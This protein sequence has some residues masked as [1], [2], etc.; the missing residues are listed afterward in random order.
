M[1]KGLRSSGGFHIVGKTD[2]HGRSPPVARKEGEEGASG[3]DTAWN[4]SKELSAGSAGVP[5]LP[6]LQLSRGCFFKLGVR[7]SG[8]G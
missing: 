2:S 4:E 6:Y 7:G 3:S 8:V 1:S 5:L